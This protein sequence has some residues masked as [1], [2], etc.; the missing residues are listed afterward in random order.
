MINHSGPKIF[1]QLKNYPLCLLNP[2]HNSQCQ[3]LPLIT[4]TCSLCTNSSGKNLWKMGSPQDTLSRLNQLKRK[5]DIMKKA[6]YLELKGLGSNPRASI[7][8]FATKHQNSLRFSFSISTKLHRAVV[9][10]MFCQLWALLWSYNWQEWIRP[11]SGWPEHLVKW[12]QV[13]FGGTESGLYGHNYKEDYIY[14][15]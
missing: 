1:W 4:S 5:W 6:M 10:K 7:C 9:R 14:E 13:K 11:D 3:W 2:V 12:I 8:S 15:L